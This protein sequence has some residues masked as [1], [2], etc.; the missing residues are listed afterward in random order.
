MQQKSIP[1]THQRELIAYF[2]LAYAISWSIQIPIALS[3]HNLIP[4]RVPLSLHYLAAFGPAGAAL[5]VTFAGSGLAG[6]QQLLRG[7]TKWRVGREYALFAGITPPALFAV[8]VLASRL[9]QGAW[10]DLGQLGQVDYLPYLGVVPALALWLLTFGLGEE[11]GWRGFALPRLQATRS[12]FGSTL[13]LG[14]LWAGWH[15]PAQFYRDTLS[16]VGLLLGI[17]ML[18]LSVMA[19][20][21]VFTWLYNGSQGSLLLVVLFHGWYNFL[22]VSAAGGEYSA[23]VMSALIVIWAVRVVNGFGHA[24]LAPREKVVVGAPGVPADG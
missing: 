15:L 2:A 20:A 24:N 17:N 11:I 1:T 19:A 22:A 6:V 12:A 9:T 8:A 3:A 23:M 13:L 5:I 7:L 16:G 10:P 4:I 21:F 14:S 18:L